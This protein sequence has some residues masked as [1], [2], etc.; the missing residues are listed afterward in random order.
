MN[1]NQLPESLN[2][3]VIRWSVE[4][5]DGS[6]YAVYYDRQSGEYMV[7]SFV[8]DEEVE[9]WTDGPTLEGDEARSFAQLH[10]LTA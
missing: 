1:Y 10:R 6:S 9:D 7:E 2:D 3:N 5:A 4:A 8:Y